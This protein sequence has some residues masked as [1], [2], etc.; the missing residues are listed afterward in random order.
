AKY[1]AVDCIIN[2][3]GIL[4]PFVKVNDI[5]F[6]LI[7]KIINVDFYGVLY[8]TKA[9]LPHLLQRPEGHIVNVSSMGGLLPVPGESIYGAAKSAV[10]LLTEG[11]R[12]ELRNTN[13][14]LTLILPG[15]MATDIKFNSGADAKP[16]TKEDLDGA[17]IKPIAANIAAEMITQGI[18]KNKNRVLIGKDM[19]IMY[20]LNKVLPKLA[21]HLLN[22]QMK[23]H[24]LD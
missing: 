16:F 17:V 12:S 8:L 7:E 21:R 22:T 15:A 2:N 4:Q 18:E 11:L 13:V 14:N 24:L 1:G 9:F 10:I 20:V 19:K 5:G 3:A 6:P 23:A